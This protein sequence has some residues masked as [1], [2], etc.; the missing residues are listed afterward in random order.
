MHDTME[1]RMR[2]AGDAALREGMDVERA[3]A[4]DEQWAKDPRWAHIQDL[5][6]IPEFTRKEIEHFF[7][8][9][10]DLEPGKWVKVEGWG[11]A[12]EAEAVVQAGLAAYVK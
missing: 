6:D 8:H 12:A 7:T 1:Q 11:D 2:G 10:K 5:G 9:Y 3:A 4:L